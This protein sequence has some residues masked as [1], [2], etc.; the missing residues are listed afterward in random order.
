MNHFYLDNLFL[1]TLLLAFEILED[2]H[3]GC[4]LATIVFDVLDEY[5]LCDKLFCITSDNA[6]NNSTMVE[7]LQ[8]HLE[9]RDIDW[10]PEVHHIPCLAHIINL[11]VQAFLQKLQVDDNSFAVT[12]DKMH[13]IARS[14][15]GSTLRWESFQRCCK[16]CTITL[17]TI[18]L[19]M[20][21][22]WNS[23]YHMVEQIVYLKCPICRYLD[24]HDAKLGQYRLTEAEWEQAEILLVFLMPF[25]YCTKRF[26]RN[27]DSP[28]IDY[29]FFAYNTMYNH[30]DDVKVALLRGMGLGLLSSST[31]MYT[32]IEEMETK[33]RIYYQKTK[34]P[35]V[36][37][38]AMIL[39]PHVKLT[40]FEEETWDDMD[41]SHYTNGCRQ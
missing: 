19:D 32:A 7:Q 41:A 20:P 9:Q 24:D 8:N 12:L 6:S 2:H 17:A 10:D 15:Q 33:L 18:P 5:D 39:N 37:G 40:L 38:D 34:F 30:I 3:T 14:I 1:Q 13:G 31:Y 16:S 28:E 23:T 25:K 35:T 4:N 26:E 36:Y 21:V 27:I 11:V 29:V 22:H